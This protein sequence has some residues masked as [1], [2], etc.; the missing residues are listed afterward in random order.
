MLCNPI[1]SLPTCS[2][3]IVKAQ[4]N[5]LEQDDYKYQVEKLSYKSLKKNVHARFFGLP[6]CPELHRTVF[7][8]NVDL[9]CFLK[10]T[11]KHNEILLNS[12]TELVKT[13]MKNKVT[14]KWILTKAAA[15]SPC[16]ICLCKS[17][18]SNYNL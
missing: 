18:D 5:L 9:G 10:V 6:V 4:Q 2:R 8:K 12:V 17:T 1:E 13:A 7:P 15:I 3:D 16:T 11:G 14:I